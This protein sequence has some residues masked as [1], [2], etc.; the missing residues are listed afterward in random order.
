MRKQRRGI[1]ILVLIIFILFFPETNSQAN[2]KQFPS[3]YDWRGE[4]YNFPVLDQQVENCN[5]GYAFAT[6]GAIQAAI[7]KKD[8]LSLDFSENNAKECNWNSIN[9]YVGD[10]MYSCKGGNSRMLINLF[11]QDGLVMEGCDPYISIDCDCNKSCSPEYYVTEWQ[12]FSANY[13]IAS[14]ELIK[15]KIIEYGPLYSQMDPKITGFADYNGGFVFY[16]NSEP[17]ANKYTHGV[18]IVGWDDELSHAGGKGAWIVKNSYGTGWGNKGY[19]TIAYGSAGIGSSLSTV[20]GWE[21]SSSF[22]KLHFYD[23]AGHTTQTNNGEFFKPNQVLAVFISEGTEIAQTVEFWSNDTAIVN[24]QIYSQFSNGNLSDKLYESLELKIPYAGY[25]SIDL[26]PN[27]EL[28]KDDEIVVVLEIKNQS[29]LFPIAVDNL[30]IPSDDRTWIKN[31]QGEW[32]SLKKWN[33]DAG[34]RLRTF[35]IPDGFNQK[36]FL[37]LIK[38]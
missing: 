14:T 32:V 19:F 4:G 37:P 15:Q 33:F 36:V 7:W 21:K 11:T 31:I 29:N 22:K 5:S 6:V 27:I 2:T 16:D 38:R 17:D 12:Q 24:L 1:L 28:K 35:V 18:L 25:Y 10:W 23:D 20:T 30:G 9:H 26:S 34:I 3:K 8:K 13:Q